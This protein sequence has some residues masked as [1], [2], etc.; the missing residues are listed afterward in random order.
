MLPWLKNR[1][2]TDL[3]ESDSGKSAQDGGSSH[4]H[5]NS[6]HTHGKFRLEPLEPRVLLSADSIIVAIG[7]QA[8][9]DAEAKEA[10]NSSTA[11]VEQADP[12]TGAESKSTDRSAGT[13]AT[14]GPKVSVAWS[15]SW[16]TG[17]ATDSETDP[18]AAY[19]S[20]VETQVL[21][22]EKTASAQAQSVQLEQAEAVAAG[23]QKPDPDTHTSLVDTSDDDQIFVLSTV[24]ELPRGPPGDEQGSSALVAQ[25]LINNNA[26]SSTDSPTGDEGGLFVVLDA[27]FNEPTG[28]AMPRAPP[29]A[30][31]SVTDEPQYLRSA[32]SLAAPAQN[33]APSLTDQALAPVLEQALRLWIAA[34]ING[35][36]ADR[37]TD[38][39]V[40]IVDLPDGLLGLAEGLSISL[41]ATAAG[42]GW[43]VDSTLDD[44]AEFAQTLSNSRSAAAGGS[45]A[46]GRI[47]LL[48]VLVHEIGHVL[49]LDHDAGLA[50]MS[51]I[52]PA[53]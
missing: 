25:E 29:V 52:L 16:L 4:T 43:F 49:S 45:E 19:I 9:M 20:D 27:P 15:E 51:E 6:S 48:T 21:L 40:R 36:L 41:D 8:L 47:D 33:S 50:I 1:S 35:S 12:D 37:L 46:Y 26:L 53:G 28:D 18:E 39:Q 23:Q 24:T 11:I 38:L 30:G 31:A 22:S 32:P 44:N 3:P 10:G 2:R 14:A 42:R 7:Y 13:D 34:G 17:S 5:R